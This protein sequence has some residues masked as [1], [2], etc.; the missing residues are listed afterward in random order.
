M[1]EKT[2]KRGSLFFMEE[3]PVAEVFTPEDFSEEHL[4]IIKTLESFIKNEIVPNMDALEREDW[5]LTRR[6][7]LQAGE[8]GFLGVDIEEEYGGSELDHIASLLVC[9]YSALSGSWGPCLNDHTGIGSMPLVF[10]GNKAQK[11]KYLP[12]LATGEKI[13]CYALTEP[14]AGTDA[15]AIQTTAVLSPDG[16][17][18]KLSGTKQY[19]TNGGFAD[20]IFTYAKIDGDKMTA[21]ILERDFEGI[22]F[23]AQ[24]KKMGLRGSSTCS[25]FLDGVKVPVE[26]VV[27]EIGRGHI[28]A[29]NI[30]NLGRFKLGAGSVGVAKLAI[31]YSV[32]YSKERVQFGKPICQ[33][34]LIK[35]KIAEMATKTYMAESMVYRTGGLIDD[36]FATVDRTAEDIGRQS[37]NSIFEY[38]VECS[39]NKV[40]CSEILD[41][42]G[43][44]AVQIYGG[45]GYCEEY[46][47]ERIYRDNRIFRIFEG[48]NEINRLL[49]IGQLVRKAL[50][51]EIPLLTVAEKV[52]EEVPAMEPLSPSADDGPL[53]YQRRLVERAKKIFLFLCGGAA[54]KYG[55]ALEEEQEILGLLSDIAQE[56]YAVESGLLRA[57]KS[58]ESSGEQRSKMKIDMV[59]LY[60]ND[61]MVRIRG[62]ARQILAAMETGEALD[63]QLATLRKV[64]QF[65]P[66]NG[67]QLRRDI[68]DGIIE[69][70]RYTC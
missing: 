19:V 17:Y 37:A 41:Y 16:K 62:Y 50:K 48:T 69:V 57:L 15:M 61:A 21:F 5:D 30:L 68:A 34:G 20:I 22:S 46:P 7:M 35:H 14:E 24:E 1:A 43:D 26:N 70:G 45:Y 52:R 2:V 64:S 8:L 32:G 33:F 23:G 38:V 29:F 42:V 66:I 6:L 31:E 11:Q 12:A 65:T 13:G 36:I 25:I 44:E 47:V 49:I 59:R 53:G 56:I 58:I 54:Q 27:H 39:I 63:S 51:N 55:M 28:V 9:E 67:V 3:V 10:F 40:Y 60:S 18:Y 4:M